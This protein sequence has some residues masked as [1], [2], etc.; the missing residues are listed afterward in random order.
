MKY[1]DLKMVSHKTYT[2]GSYDV[3]YGNY[4]D[5]KPFTSKLI[6]TNVREK[7]ISE[8]KSRIEQVIT[9]IGGDIQLNYVKEFDCVLVAWNV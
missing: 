6:A 4:D 8:I 2:N 7:D 5:N 1:E 3:N 9:E